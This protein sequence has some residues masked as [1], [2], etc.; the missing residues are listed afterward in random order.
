MERGVSRDRVGFVQNI[1]R[2][3]KQRFDDFDMAFAVKKKDINSGSSAFCA[4]ASD[5]FLFVSSSANNE[6][7]S[8][9]SATGPVSDAAAA[10]SAA[11]NMDGCVSAYS[12]YL[13]QGESGLGL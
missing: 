2:N 8:V 4:S 10:M 12:T 1:F 9:N 11:T 6:V 7:A 13:Y 5:C 3:G